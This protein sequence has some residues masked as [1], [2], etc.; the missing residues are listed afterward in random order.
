MKAV[1]IH[2][3]GGPEVLV[4]E[5]VERPVP[6]P[7][8]ALIE[9]RAAGVNPFDV[10]IREGRFITPIEP[11]RIIGGDGAGV[12]V[13]VGDEVTAVHA[14]DE[15]LF[16]GLGIGS[17]GSYAEYALIAEV[18]AVP[19]PP[20]LSFVDAAAMG[21]VFP[22]A[23]YA[24][25]RRAAVRDGETV[26]VQGAA[27]GI[28]SAAVQLA[29]VLGAR[30]IG[31]VRRARD[32]QPVLELGAEDVIDVSSQDLHEQI[33]TLT[34]GRGVDVVVEIATADNLPADLGVVV[35]GGR[36]VCVGQGREAEAVVPFGLASSLD[37][38]LL[39][40]SSSN[41]GRAG[42]AQM[43][44]EVGQMVEDGRVRPVVG[45]ALP[46]SEARAAHELLVGEHFGKIV[47]VP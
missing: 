46:L 32:V 8:Q 33:H 25:Q 35:K 20:S 9:V 18:Q 27:G 4:H 29:R 5:E 37:V 41:A 11:P 23:L 6:G 24:L 43:L 44:R 30:P 14:G 34:G 12:V 47:L 40:M 19:K 31:I 17:Q 16:T 15:V 10:T 42:T 21:L 3:Y 36:I 1:R 22:T 38:S 39:Y 7:K 2:G 26:L 13:E 45:A 28:G